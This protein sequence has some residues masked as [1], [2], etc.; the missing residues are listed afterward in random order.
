MQRLLKSIEFHWFSSPQ[1][2]IISVAGDSLNLFWKIW[3]FWSKQNRI[4]FDEICFLKDVEQGHNRKLTHISFLLSLHVV[5]MKDNSSYISIMVWYIWWQCGC[6][7][8]K[9]TLWKLTHISFLS[10]WH[11]VKMKDNSSYISIMVWYIC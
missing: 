5:K 9:T 8:W 6:G 4:L 1:K 10:S 3:T 7:K 2:V 11:V